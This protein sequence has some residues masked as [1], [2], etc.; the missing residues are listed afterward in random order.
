MSIQI[1]VVVPSFVLPFLP[2]LDNSL[3]SPIIAVVVAALYAALIFLAVFTFNSGKLSQLAFINITDA[4]ALVT[5]PHDTGST[6]SPVAGP[7]STITPVLVSL[8]NIALFHELLASRIPLIK[9]I[10][11]GSGRLDY[12]PSCRI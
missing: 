4:A 3:G 1:D 7:S 12:L 9:N 10:E 11:W 8:V 5:T 6:A 2:F